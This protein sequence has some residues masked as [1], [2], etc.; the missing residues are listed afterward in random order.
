MPCKCCF[1]VCFAV[2]HVAMTC[3]NVAS[4]NPPGALQQDQI[5]QRFMQVLLQRPREGTALDR[6]YGYHIQA[7]TMDRFVKELETA[8][9]TPGDDQ[10]P[11][12]TLLGLIEMRRGRDEKAV[13]ALKRAEPLMVDDAMVSYYLGRS[14]R[15]AGDEEAAAAAFRR[16]LDRGPNRNE[17]LPVFKELARLYHRIGH[18]EKALEVWHELESVFPGDTRISE[19]VAAALAEEGQLKQ[20]LKRYEQLAQPSGRSDDFRKVGFQIASAELKRRLGMHQAATADLEQILR[21]LRPGSWLHRDVRHRIE[22]GFLRSG[23]YSALAEYYAEQTKQSPNDVDAN[24]RYGRTL[25]KAGRLGEAADVL[26]GIVN[27]APQN[28][29]VRLSL[30]DVYTELG[31][32]SLAADQYQTLAKLESRESRLLDAVGYTVAGDP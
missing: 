18:N 22:V 21:R 9:A 19:Q 17:A 5:T 8:A 24:L 31:E 15:M 1:L 7:G 23:D 2:C 20:A 13:T 28:V 26:R 14:L 6:V 27:R 3:N 32:S 12:T 11:K 29:D 30:I 10:G 25:A 4:K 16:A